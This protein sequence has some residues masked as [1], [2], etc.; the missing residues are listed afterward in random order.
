LND[1]ES[2]GRKTC[3]KKVLKLLKD[4]LEHLRLN[5]KS[6]DKKILCSYHLKTIMLSCYDD[7]YRI[8]EWEDR[9]ETV[10]KRYIDALRK[11]VNCLNV[12]KIDHYFIMDANL[13]EV[14][15]NGKKK[16]MIDYFN[17]KIKEFE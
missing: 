11:L 9:Q 1:R 12:W 13:L 8:E 5:K 14:E 10:R 7:R 4:D 6:T 16:A 15:D 17:E 3:R 2:K